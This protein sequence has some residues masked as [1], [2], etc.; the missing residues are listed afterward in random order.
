LTVQA[1]VTVRCGS[2][3]RYPP[4]T[5]M[6]AGRI[7]R[8]ASRTQVGIASHSFRRRRLTHSGAHALG[9]EVT[10][11]AVGVL[12]EVFGDVGV[13]GAD[14]FAEDLVEFGG[15][16]RLCAISVSGTVSG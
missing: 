2:Q 8:L 5:L 10:Q 7:K 13:A 1:T 15:L 11:Q 14:E 16:D 9:H 6:T 3:S 12:V 4:S